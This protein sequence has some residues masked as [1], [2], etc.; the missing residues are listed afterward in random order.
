M[1]TNCQ[2][3]QCF[4]PPKFRAIREFSL[5]LN[6]S[7]GEKLEP[8]LAIQGKQFTRL[9]YIF[10]I[11]TVGNVIYSSLTSQTIQY[12]LKK[13]V[14]WLVRLKY[15]GGVTSLYFELHL[16]SKC[17]SKVKQ[18]KSSKSKDK[19]VLPAKKFCLSEIVYGNI[20]GFKLLTQFSTSFESKVKRN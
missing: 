14:D 11:W 9:M 3:H 17:K 1:D 15:K 13:K 8:E 12:K 4:L 5:I 18:R 7:V 6:L 2:I 20:L 10:H 19:Q 16:W